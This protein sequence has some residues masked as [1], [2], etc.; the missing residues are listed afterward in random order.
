MR[1]TLTDRTLPKLA[2][3]KK[4]E[5]Q[6]ECLEDCEA[7][8]HDACPEVLLRE[9]AFGSICLCDCHD[10]PGDD[11]NRFIPRPR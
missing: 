7:G 5:P 10:T 8:R 4:G 9:G 11:P 1:V 6:G 3:P 2:P